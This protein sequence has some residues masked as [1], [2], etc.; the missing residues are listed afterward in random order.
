MPVIPVA[1]SEEFANLP[2]SPAETRRIVGTA[3]MLI[4]S[5]VSLAKDVLSCI[6]TDEWSKP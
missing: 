3:L 5:S 1:G 2:T 6:P 4:G